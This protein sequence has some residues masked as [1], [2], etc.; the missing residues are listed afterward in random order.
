M[1][2]EG[3]EEK[4]QILDFHSQEQQ[5]IDVTDAIDFETRRSLHDKIQATIS[6]QRRGTICDA[7]SN[8]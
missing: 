4:N 6:M 1:E 7:D 5:T 3:K 2:V 8:A